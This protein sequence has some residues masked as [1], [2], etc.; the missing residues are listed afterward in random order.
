MQGEVKSKLIANYKSL[1]YKNEKTA[2]KYHF[3]YNKV[4]VN[5]Y[6]DNYD[7]D[8]PCFSMILKY[9]KDYYYTS[10]NIHRPEIEKE[11]LEGI[12]NS[13]LER[14][15]DKNNQLDVFFGDVKNRIMNDKFFPIYYNN[16]TF[17]TNTLKNIKNDDEKPFLHHFRRRKMTNHTLEL[18]A[19]TS[20]ID[21]SILKKLQAEGFTI[22]RTADPNKRRSLNFEMERIRL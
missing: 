22:I 7:E 13:I 3:Q 12:Q 14:I 6:F 8:F 18:L 1:R 2:I 15:L 16:D 20:S 9:E 5:L 10:L 19:R 11:Y 17:F 21:K 4:E